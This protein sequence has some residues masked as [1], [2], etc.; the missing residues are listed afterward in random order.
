MQLSLTCASVDPQLCS[1]LF[2]TS[3]V[4]FGGG[5]IWALEKSL[6][7]DSHTL[8][9]FCDTPLLK[10]LSVYAGCAIMACLLRF[11]CLSVGATLAWTARTCNLTEAT[12]QAMNPHC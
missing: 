9:Y 11:V 7:D 10:G 8:G 3:V 6:G 1:L 5:C 2:G 12:F 4:V